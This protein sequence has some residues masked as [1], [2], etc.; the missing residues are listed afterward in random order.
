[1]GVH[2]LWQLLE[3]SGRRLNVE[4][5]TGKV[6]AVD[7]SIWISQ[8]IKAMRDDRGDMMKN[9]HLLGFFRRICKMLFHKI[10]PVFVFDG[11]TPALKK[12]T[13]ADRRRRREVQEAKLK[14]VAEKLLLNHLKK[15]R[16]AARDLP[17]Q[18]LEIHK[19]SLNQ[20]DRGGTVE[21]MEHETALQPILMDKGKQ[22]VDV[23]TSG[24]DAD[25]EHADMTPT[26]LDN[27]HEE[28]ESVVLPENIAEMDPQALS[29][30]PPSMQFDV[31]L[32]MREKQNIA[33]REQYTQA[34]D[35][36]DFSS[37]QISAYLKSTQFKQRIEDIR[38]VINAEAQPDKDNSG[39]PIMTEAGRE[40]ILRTAPKAP[41]KK[42]PLKRKKGIEE[43]YGEENRKKNAVL[44]PMDIP[45]WLQQP[46]RTSVDAVGNETVSPQKLDSVG[47]GPV[48][49]ERAKEGSVVEIDIDTCK[50]DSAD[51]DDLFGESLEEDETN[52]P[53]MEKP[54]VHVPSNWRERAATRQK[55]WSLAHGFKMGRKLSEWAAEEDEKG[56]EGLDEDKELE[57]ALKLS[58][59]EN[60]CANTMV[61]AADE[62][63]FEWQDA[64]SEPLGTCGNLLHSLG[65]ISQR[66]MESG[67]ALDKPST[68]SAKENQNKA[69]SPN[70][71]ETAN[72][73]L[74]EGK[75]TT[76]AVDSSSKF[77]PLNVLNV[78]T[79]KGDS[80][81]DCGVFTAHNKPSGREGGFLQP[82]GDNLRV[83][84]DSLEPAQPCPV[85][86]MAEYEEPAFGSTSGTRVN[87]RDK[88]VYKN[89][90]PPSDIRDV[91]SAIDGERAA[92]AHLG[93]LD[94]AD[95]EELRGAR[96]AAG[97]AAETPTKDMF[98]DVMQLLAIFGIPYIIA[99]ME[100]EA[101]CAW[102]NE[103]GLVDGVVTDD[104]D[105]FL[106]GGQC[107]YRHM[108]E[109]RKYVEEY[110]AST[111]REELG[112]DREKLIHL[113]LL[114]GSDYTEGITGVGIVNAIEIVHAF[115]GLDG[116]YDFR[117]WVETP[118]LE[119]MLPG[120]HR[121]L[122]TDAQRAFQ[123]KHG[124]IRRNWEIHPSF[125]SESVVQAYT[126][127]HV[128]QGRDRFHWGPPDEALLLRFCVQQLGMDSSQAQAHL[129]P[130]FASQQDSLVQTR[131]DAFYSFKERFAKIRSRRIRDAVAGITKSRGHLPALASDER[132]G[133]DVDG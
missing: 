59:Q 128:D 124:G 58:L 3:P 57:L 127:P 47:T 70:Q 126:H 119:G 111:V 62:E 90:D 19:R 93:G 132:M 1:M 103:Q 77:S 66:P 117:E 54:Q 123:R 20:E 116:L 120:V 113:A 125:P 106:F 14:R 107:I 91:P 30:L 41:G 104:S 15:Q 43:T 33:N 12:R 49:K 88:P 131:L 109:E 24:V 27:G 97:V 76:V 40:Y 83:K 4:L 118:D 36:S 86:N 31:L 48:G 89:V 7:A 10:K 102:L 79:E 73:N 72:L 5:L 22:P 68:S 98:Q 32:K 2:G 114:L 63:G 99:P 110:K 105:V 130:V 26:N 11:G 80:Q 17:K 121:E 95:K 52:G 129:A 67:C 6:L 34:Q 74:G 25:D 21:C 101:Q 18:D 23:E 45:P 85:P 87:T 46:Q 133:S 75:E 61:N 122:S 35:P 65:S 55:F 115:P 13:V 8:F 60:Q 53:S 71:T 96:R 37:M 16:S 82:K 44:A 51:I 112:L 78:H 28:D 38:G 84:S 9:A 42:T 29:A 56:G 81:E 50:D 100:A 69:A 92:A 108:F 94:D 39:R 64:G